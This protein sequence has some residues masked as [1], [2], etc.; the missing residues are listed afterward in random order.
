MLG[1]FPITNNQWREVVR[2]PKIDIDIPLRPSLPGGK[3]HPVVRISWHEAQEFCNRLRQKSGHEYRL[4]TE[5]EWEYAC[6]AGT[7]T[8]FHFGHFLDN[9]IV[10]CNSSCT[11]EVDS[12]LFSIA[13]GLYDLHGNVWEWCQDHWHGSYEG[14]PV[15]SNPWL[16]L[17]T[18]TNRVL[19]GGSWR[20]E[21]GLCRSACRFFDYAHSRSDNVGFRIAYSI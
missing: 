15:D 21:P 14:A 12:L 20:N 1:K 2:L 4:P 7:M 6:R 11:S 8:P 9:N 5:A 17:E 19:R 13:F 3:K 10:N 18:N 16:D